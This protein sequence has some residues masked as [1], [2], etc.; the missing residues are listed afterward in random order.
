MEKA[1]E[2]EVFALEMG[3]GLLVMADKGRVGTFSNE[4]LVLERILPKKWVC[5]YLQSV[6]VIIS[7]L[8]LMST[9]FYFAGKEIARS[10]VM[11]DR[12]LAMNMGAEMMII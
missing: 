2:Q 5:F 4:L 11:P 1:I 9:A 7:N 12:F 8:S 3:Y 10:S 6:C